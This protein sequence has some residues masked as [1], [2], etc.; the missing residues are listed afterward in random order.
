MIVCGGSLA[1]T[2]TEMRHRRSATERLK[3]GMSDDVSKPGTRRRAKPAATPPLDPTAMF[4]ALQTALNAGLSAIGGAGAAVGSVPGPESQTTGAS[5]A[6]DLAPIIGRAMLTAAGSSARYLRDMAVLCGKHQTSLVQLI[7]GNAAK[8]GLTGQECRVAADELRAFLRE[9][10]ETAALEAH[11]LQMELATLSEAVGEIAARDT[12]PD[13]GP[14][15][16]W[17]AKT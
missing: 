8:Q 13:A 7:G 17:R 6:P 14:T 1:L 10:G 3:L 9:A 12:A 4:G 2:P 16:R 15:R 5:I 11:R